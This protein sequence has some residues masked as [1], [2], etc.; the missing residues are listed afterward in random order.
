[1]VSSDMLLALHARLLG[2]LQQL[3]DFGMTVLSCTG[4]PPGFRTCFKHSHD[5]GRTVQGGEANAFGRSTRLEKQ[6]HDLV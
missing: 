2:T 4:D 6:V 1:M 3:H 5:L